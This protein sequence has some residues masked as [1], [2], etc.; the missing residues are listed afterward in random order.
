LKIKI[1]FLIPTLN[2]GGAEKQ[3][4]N[5]LNGLNTN[6][7][8]IKL[9][10]L[11][12]QIQLIEQLNNDSIDI[13]IL[14]IKSV[15]NLK[16]Y[17]KLIQELRVFS[18]HILHS[19]MYNAN[20]LARLIKLFIPKVK[21]INHYHGLSNWLTGTK[22]LLD[23]LTNRLVDKHIVVSKPSYNLRLTREKYKE[24]DLMLFPNSVDFS[25]IPKELEI[26]EVKVIGI[27]SRLIP[28]KNI[29]GAIHLF[30]SLV[31]RCPNYSLIIAGDGP[32]RNNLEQLVCELG[33]QDKI[34]FL[35]FVRDM[36][37]FFKDID[38]YC[39]SSFTEDLP[40]SVLEALTMGKPIVSS[41]VGGIPDVL[42]P[43][44]SSVI[45]DDFLSNEDVEKAI[46]FIISIDYQFAFHE[47]QNYAL[48]NF[49]NRSYCEKLSVLYNELVG[50]DKGCI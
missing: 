27:A 50:Q 18:P 47:T 22:L 40:L 39:I 4:I 41:N 12:D 31:A 49:S 33:L 6:K 8:D 15:F 42:A 30:S 10:V 20:F 2:L 36:N 26:H 29:K 43:I 1:A 45:L 48:D 19:Q 28:L 24:K 13:E 34:S 38:I 32:E 21:L 14:S 35:G 11:K 16:K 5:I 23:K 7:Y 3:Q 46:E 37:R 17:Y 25:Y 44:T 9:F